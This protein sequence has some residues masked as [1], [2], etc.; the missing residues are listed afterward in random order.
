[1]KETNLEITEIVTKLLTVI[2]LSCV[3]GLIKNPTIL[4]NHIQAIGRYCLT[5]QGEM[6]GDLIVNGSI[7]EST[8]TSTTSTPDVKDNPLTKGN[9][10]K[11]PRNAL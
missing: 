4:A 8:Q 9:Q 7:A 2:E 1:M 6:P 3:R 11:P 5:L 10:A